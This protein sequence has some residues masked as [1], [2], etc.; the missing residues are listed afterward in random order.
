MTDRE[1]IRRDVIAHY[2]AGVKGS[3]LAEYRC[4]RG[5]LLLH[6]WQS[7]NGPEFFA[8]GGRVSDHYALAFALAVKG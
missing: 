7:P 2:E 5:C 8:P 3:L 4:K 6:V 1:S